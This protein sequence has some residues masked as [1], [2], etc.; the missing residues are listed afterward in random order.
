MKLARTSGDTLP[1]G[2]GLHDRG[3]IAAEP[4]FAQT[5]RTT[6]W[7]CGTSTAA[8]VLALVVT[9]LLTASSDGASALQAEAN[10]ELDEV[11]RA[12]QRWSSSPAP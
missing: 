5:I 9:L 10:G 6:G 8:A 11:A 12:K 4:V 3:V 7:I 2:A 1:V